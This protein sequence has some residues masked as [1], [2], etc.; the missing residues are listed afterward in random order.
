[1]AVSV[2]RRSSWPTGQLLGKNSDRPKDQAC[3][4]SSIAAKDGMPLGPETASSR[5]LARAILDFLRQ[6]RI[7]ARRLEADEQDA[8][9]LG[10]LN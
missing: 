7:E 4:S 8:V 6:A 1:M 3:V 9:S 5:E 10:D 2:P